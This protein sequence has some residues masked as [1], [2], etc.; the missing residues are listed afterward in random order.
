[1][2]AYNKFDQFVEDLGVGVHNLAAAGDELQFYLT[3]NA[4]SSSADA[5]KAD[6]VGA[7]EQ[8]GYAAA[9]AI[10]DYSQTG[11]IATLTGTTKVWT[12]T[13]GGFGPVRYVVLNNDTP[14]SPA[15]PLI[16]WWDYGSSVSPA[17]GETFTVT[18][19]ASLF[20]L[21]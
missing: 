6:L 4:P 20:V 5:V 3:N 17:S 19:G 10:Q 16:A 8:N 15:D 7:T 9:D 1:M 12:A 14:T 13:A 2:V 21:E 11:G 18:V